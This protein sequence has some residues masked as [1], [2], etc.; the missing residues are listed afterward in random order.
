MI[1]PTAL[2]QT[3][4]LPSRQSNALQIAG[5]D[6]LEFNPPEVEAQIL[7]RLLE[8]NDPPSPKFGVKELSD[9]EEDERESE[10]GEKTVEYF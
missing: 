6:L 3:Q 9:D 7:R 2:A 1:R 5:K 8:D 4:R 10:N